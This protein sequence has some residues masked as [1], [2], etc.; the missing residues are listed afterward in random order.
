MPLKPPP[1]IRKI[2][3]QIPMRS[4][5]PM[6]K[7]IHGKENDASSTKKHPHPPKAAAEVKV[8]HRPFVNNQP[9]NSSRQQQNPQKEDDEVVEVE[10]VEIC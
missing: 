2:K 8:N 4:F 10:V 9:V 6:R 1:V 3:P 7:C 5:H